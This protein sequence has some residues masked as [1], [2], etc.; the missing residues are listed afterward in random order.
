M[1]KS[2]II[3]KIYYDL[4]GYGSIQNTLKEARKYD[5][6]ITYDDVRNWKAKQPLGQK[7]QIRGTNRFIA[8]EP[9]EEFQIDLMFFTD[10]DKNSVA[11][12]MGDIFTKFTHIVEIQSKQPPD[13]LVGIGKCFEKWVYRVASIAILKVLSLVI[14]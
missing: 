5:N 6:T 3:E 10:V 14:L 7:R 2:D 1:S 11:L 13:V 4:A 9:L 8:K 12:L